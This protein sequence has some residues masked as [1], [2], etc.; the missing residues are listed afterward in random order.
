MII[1]MHAH[2]LSERFLADLIKTLKPAYH[3]SATSGANLCF[4]ATGFRSQSHLIGI[5]MICRHGL[6]ASGAA[7]SSG[8]YSRRRRA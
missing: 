3:A 6:Q 5:Y 8:R 1:D 7:K 2:G 4:L